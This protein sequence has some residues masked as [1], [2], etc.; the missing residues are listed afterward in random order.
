MR[1]SGDGLLRTTTAEQVAQRLQQ[2]I[3]TGTL[4]PG[5]RLRQTEIANRFGVSTTPVREAFALLQAD[6]LV[7]IDAHKGAVVYRPTLEEMSESYEIR[8]ALE[9]LAIAKA[10]P[11]LTTADIDTLDELIAQMKEEPNDQRW[12]DLNNRF[13][14]TIYR[15]S[16]MGQLCSLID[17]IR[18]ASSVYIHMFVA[19]Q[20]AHRS[21]DEHEEILAACKAGDVARAQRA[22]SAHLGHAVLEDRR[23]L[24]DD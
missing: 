2:E 18:N 23:L 17:Q 4:K 6:G 8:E 12:L 7:R 11:N 1:A 20:D 19:H 22:I 16:G 24:Q 5:T 3:R 21:D 14:M 9:R 10:I 13:H 15:A